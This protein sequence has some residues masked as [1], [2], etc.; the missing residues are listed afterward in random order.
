MKKILFSCLFLFS[1]SIHS[2]QP[3]KA[4]YRSNFNVSQ[5]QDKQVC[6][7]WDLNSVVFEKKVRICKM[8]SYARKKKGTKK[9]IKALYK[10]LKLRKLKKKLKKQKNPHGFAWDAMLSR[11]AKKD[12]K[13]ADFLRDFIQKANILDVRM[14]NLMQRL[15]HHG[16]V[17]GVLSNMGQGLLDAQIEH[18][19]EKQAKKPTVSKFVLNFL[20]D[21]DHKVIADQKNNWMQKPDGRMY[22]TFLDKNAERRKDKI[23]IF[24]DDKLENVQGAIENGFDIGIH[25][26]KGSTSRQLEEILANELKIAH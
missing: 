25:Y 23:T 2:V 15:S 13:T 11:L 16:H 12:P 8:L 18:L 1:L 17:H 22:K 9:T 24:I 26:P 4:L 14:V 7:G 21:H 6:F 10:F 20:Q 19:K 3:V 5:A